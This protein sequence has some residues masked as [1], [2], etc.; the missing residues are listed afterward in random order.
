M[1]HAALTAAVTLG[2]QY[3]IE[4]HPEV[5]PYL[6]AATPVVC[7]VAHGTNANPAA[8]VD[9][10]MASGLGTNAEAKIII[11]GSLALLNIAVAGV[12]TNQ[13]EV[14][15]YVLDLCNGMQAG[16]PPPG[17]ARAKRKALPPHLR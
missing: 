16:L 5:L 7:A 1:T 11:N 17:P 3:G 14:T 15:L 2:E 12:G 6:R 13:P 4:S 8:V 10:L 9:A